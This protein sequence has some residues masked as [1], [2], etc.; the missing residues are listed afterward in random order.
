M[1]SVA[2]VVDLVALMVDLDDMAEG[3]GR[4]IHRGATGDISKLKRTTG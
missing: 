1:G 2:L 3:N 4:N